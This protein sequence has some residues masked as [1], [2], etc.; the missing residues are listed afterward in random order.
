MNGLLVQIN[1]IISLL[2]LDVVI[3]FTEELL[4]YDN[5]RDFELFLLEIKNNASFWLVYNKSVNIK[6]SAYDAFLE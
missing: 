2:W 3:E 5:T 1:N 6:F 4:F